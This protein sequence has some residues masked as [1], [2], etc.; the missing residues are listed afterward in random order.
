MRFKDV[1]GQSAAIG[2]LRAMVDQDRLPHALLLLGNTG[3]GSL[4][5]GLALI[6]YA[7]CDQRTD[8]DA[9]GICPQCTK[10]S[11]WI[12]PDVHF[13]FPVIKRDKD[14]P[15]SSDYIT[16]WRTALSEN[17]Y[18]HEQAWYDRLEAGNKQ[19]NITAEECNMIL[20][21]LSFRAYEGRYKVLLLW[22][23]EY[24]SKE[25]SR[26]LKF[27]EE[28][29]G[30]TLIVMVAE[31]QDLILPTILSRCQLVKILPLQDEM[32]EEALMKRFSLPKA[33]AL[34]LAHLAEGDWSEALH[35]MEQAEQDR[36]GLF[37]DWMRKCYRGDASE[38]VQWV[39]KFATLGREKQKYFLQYGLHFLR[40]M[41]DFIVSGS[42]YLRLLPAELETARRMAASLDFHKITAL[43]Q[44]FNDC[45][46][47]IERNA[48]PKI[49]ML[50]ASIQVNTT[51]NQKN[52]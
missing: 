2:Q 14:K 17:P 3:Y 29:P 31:N 46:F 6:Q 1:I 18:L 32:I 12:H 16:E 5:V 49:L 4:A 26:L 21:Q 30:D 37:F 28:P 43:A 50:D 20:H 19:G 27:I 51:F 25:G 10:S 36:S 48:N 39:D 35:L 52:S 24:L 45:I 40:E 44:L 7:L 34:T 13:T 33:E 23:P 42:D 22:L 11:K 15:V 47:Y 38:M 9:C 41:L 8:G